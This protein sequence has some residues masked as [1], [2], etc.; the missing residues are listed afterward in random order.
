MHLNG[1]RSVMPRRGGWPWRRERDDCGSRGLARRNNGRLAGRRGRR[2]QT[3]D[4]GERD[5]LHEIGDRLALFSP[6]GPSVKGRQP[7][8]VVRLK[9]PIEIQTRVR[10]KIMSPLKNRLSLLS[11]G[12]TD[13][14]AKK[15]GISRA[16]RQFVVS[17]G[18]ILT[19]NA[20][21]LGLTKERSDFPSLSTFWPPGSRCRYTGCPGRCCRGPRRGVSPDSCSRNRR[22]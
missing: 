15:R 8:V 6:R 20:T 3:G 14:A 11:V 2:P 12:A 16:A 1:T 18:W 22:E 5:T 10:G 4:M 21:P 9:R 13:A 7:P 17:R 19:R